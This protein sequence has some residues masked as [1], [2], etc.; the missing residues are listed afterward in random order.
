[1][2]F[3]ILTH[4]FAFLFFAVL[5]IACH[6]ENPDPDLPELNWQGPGMY[7]YDAVL[8]SQ[9]RP[10]NVYYHIPVTCRPDD[11]VL[12][13]LHGNG[14]D[15]KEIRD[16]FAPLADKKHFLVV[17]PEFSEENFPGSD[18][19]HLGNLFTD[20]DHPSPETQN[21]V[22]E[23]SFSVIDP[24]FSD[25]KKNTGALAGR[26]DLF[27]HSAGAQVAHRTALFLPGEYL[28]RVVCSAAGWYTLPDTDIPFPYGLDHGP[29]P[30]PDLP[31][32]FNQEMYIIVGTE[33]TDPNS[34]GLRHNDLADA[35]GLNRFDRAQYFYIENL[36]IAQE[37]GLAFRWQYFSVPNA[38]H[39]LE[40]MASFAADRLYP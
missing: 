14:R 38:G 6:P 28:N 20:G 32:F 7:S 3:T 36:K 15:G 13:V 27:G 30:A 37:K 4:R 2:I 40:K 31:A 39:E 1:M 29:V 21:P 23:W 34:F 11:P 9:I 19:Y 22:S 16:A 18:G 8:G 35:Q 25:F 10:M 5:F 24:I 17:A 26:Y 33:D 12:M